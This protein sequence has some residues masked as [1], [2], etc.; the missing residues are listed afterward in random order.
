MSLK[1]TYTKKPGEENALSMMLLK[2]T[3]HGKENFP[4]RRSLEARG[5]KPESTD[6]RAAG[7]LSSACSEEPPCYSDSAQGG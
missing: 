1:T 2:S 3:L 7:A 4:F 6:D 5:C